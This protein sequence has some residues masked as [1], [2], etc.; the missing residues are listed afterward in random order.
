MKTQFKT[1][2][3]YVETF[4][5]D[6]QS[7]LQKIRQAV[8]EAAP[9]AVETISYQM[10]AFKLN[11]RVLVYFAAFKSHIGFYPTPSGI[12]S[13]EKELSPYQKGK[14]TAQFPLNKP[15]PFDLVKRIV[16]YRVKEDL[17][18]RAAPKSAAR[19]GY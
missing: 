13:F 2:D 9:D 17:A 3:E 12:A 10:P 7:V 15:I 18:K 11:G 14:G 1:I 5:K 16:T 4:P 19:K 8:Q 6:V